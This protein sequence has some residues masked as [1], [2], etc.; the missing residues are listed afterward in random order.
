[1]ESA[2]LSSKNQITVPRQVR[3]ALSIHSGDRIC[4]QPTGDG[5]FLVDSVPQP[6]R[7][8]GAARRRLSGTS[9]PPVDIDATVT[10][11]VLDEDRR[12]RQAN[13]ET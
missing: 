6:K 13:S 12:I 4:F 1:M 8:D 7:S 2:K 10:R 11:A 9:H 3:R 5:R